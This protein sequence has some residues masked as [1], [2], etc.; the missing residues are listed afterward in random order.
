M[1]DIKKEIENAERREKGRK[2]GEGKSD[3]DI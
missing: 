3:K 2:R 1:R